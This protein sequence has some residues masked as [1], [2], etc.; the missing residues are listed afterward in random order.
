MCL[1]ESIIFIKSDISLRNIISPRGIFLQYYCS[2]N[3]VGLTF[4]DFAL[5]IFF[6]SA[7]FYISYTYLLLFALSSVFLYRLAFVI[8]LI[9]ISHAAQKEKGKSLWAPHDK[10]K[11][12]KIKIT[13]IHT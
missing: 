1:N 6:S 11:K 13:Y 12:K 5:V 2:I 9:Y 10:K 4:I 7:I 3:D 8:S